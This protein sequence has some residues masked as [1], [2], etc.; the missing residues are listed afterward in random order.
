MSPG[1]QNST[2]LQA[3][4]IHPQLGPQHPPEHEMPSEPASDFVCDKCSAVD[5]A[6]LPKLADDRPRMEPIWAMVMASLDLSSAELGASSCKVCQLLSHIKLPLYDGHHCAL[7]AYSGMWG[8]TQLRVISEEFHGLSKRKLDSLSYDEDFP[9]LTV[10]GPGDYKDLRSMR[11]QSDHVD[12][13]HYDT[14]TS[15]MRDCQRNHNKTC[16]NLS[17]TP[18]IPG[19]RVIDTESRKVVEAPP[20]CQYLALSYVWGKVKHSEDLNNAP[21]VIADT[22][23]LCARLGFKYIWIDQY[24]SI[25]PAAFSSCSTTPKQKKLTK[26]PVCASQKPREAANLG[27]DG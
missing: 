7:Y 18:D 22:F 20:Q 25:F 3:Q 4:R 19:L 2:E 10:I 15:I 23:N 12:P 1:T 27:Y 16:R 24:A 14:L 6:Q 26:V 5:W 13:I 11:T 21:P 9:S 8:Y 17:R